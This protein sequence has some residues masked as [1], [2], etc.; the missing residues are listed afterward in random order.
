MPLSDKT[1]VFTPVKDLVSK[2]LVEYRLRTS[3]KMN[4]QRLPQDAQELCKFWCLRLIPC[5]RNSCVFKVVSTNALPSCPVLCK[6]L[7]ISINSAHV[8][9]LCTFST[10][11]AHVWPVACIIA[12][13]MSDAV[14]A[15]WHLWLNPTGISGI[16][17]SPSSAMLQSCFKVRRGKQGIGCLPKKKFGRGVAW[18][19]CMKDCW[20]WRNWG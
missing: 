20:N 11:F 16:G 2:A 1:R 15:T 8:W 18:R 5:T 14:T 7:Q 10:N 9:N 17:V 4:T 19:A 13:K 6:C 12:K 3:F